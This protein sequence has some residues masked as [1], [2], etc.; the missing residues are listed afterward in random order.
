MD[1][2]RRDLQSVLNSKFGKGKAII[3]IGPR[4]VGKTTLLKK[5]LADAGENNQV[6]Y[7]NCDEGDVRTM[8]S[9]VS[10]AILK[11]LIG[12]SR[13][14]VI[15]EAQRVQNIGLALKLIHDNFP[16]L[17]LAVTGSSSL[18]LSNT[19][20]E[21]MTGRK[22]EYN[23]FPFSTNELVLHTSLLEERRHLENRL[24]Y[25]LYPD[26]VNNPG[27]EKE[28]LSNIVSS[29]LYKDVFEFQDVRKPAVIE[30]LVQA[31]SLQIGSE[32]S[33][34]ELGNLLGIDTLTVQRYVDLLEK[35]YVVFHLHSYSRN[36]RNELKKSIKIYFYDNG[37]RNA[38]I[39]NYAPCELRND[40]GA[41]WENFLISERVKNN[42][43]HNRKAKYYFWRTTQ[44][45]E[46]DFIEERDG[47]FSSFEFKYNPNKANAK[48]PLTFA[49]NYPEIPFTVITKENYTDFVMDV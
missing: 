18:D 2:I 36:V 30:K 29:Y 28:I 24:V 20:N 45:Q 40:L 42:A 48:C 33:F 37:V 13:L 9:E 22:F 41:L 32:V 27:D 39:A 1:E 3:L 21:P 43:F 10:T 12:N 8:L 23:L 14:I 31:L 49:K 16:D 38:V 17:Q 19:I 34:N 5:L 4:Q 44:K 11:S 47:A 15:D 35:A 7:W 26:V 6:Q 46:I 25:G